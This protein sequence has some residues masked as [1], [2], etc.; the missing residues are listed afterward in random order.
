MMH[1]VP[2]MLMGLGVAKPR[3]FVEEW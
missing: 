3:I 1:D 2:L